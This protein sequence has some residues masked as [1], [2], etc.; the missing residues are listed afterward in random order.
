LFIE[1]SVEK[2]AAM[3]EKTRRESEELIQRV[4]TYIYVKKCEKQH[5]KLVA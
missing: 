2:R 3:T 5:Y 4:C 1:V